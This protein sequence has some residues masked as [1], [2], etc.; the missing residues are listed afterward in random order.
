MLLEADRLGIPDD[1]PSEIPLAQPMFGRIVASDLFR[2][3]NP[4]P[5]RPVDR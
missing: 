2:H 3:L 4:T 1:D 5:S